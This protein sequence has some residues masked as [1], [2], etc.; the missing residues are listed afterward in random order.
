MT[1]PLLMSNPMRR[2]RASFLSPRRPLNRTILLLGVMIT[3]VVEPFAAESHA[4]SPD[5]PSGLRLERLADPLGI[6]RGRPSLGW[7]IRHPEPNQVQTAYQIQV[8][9]GRG[10]FFEGDPD[11]WDSGKVV[12]A[13]SSD[14]RYEGPE[15]APHAVYAWRVRVWDRQDRPSGYS[16]PQRFVTGVGEHWGA[17]P[18]WAPPGENA[19]NFC[20]LRHEFELPAGAIEHAIVHVT[21]TSPEPASQYVYQLFING[22]FVGCG[23]ER[24]FLGITRYNTYDVTGRV[25]ANAVNAIGALNHAAEGRQFLLR[26]DVLYRDGTR[27][28]IG[29]DGDWRAMDGGATYVDGGNA[30]HDSYYY[31]PRE[32]IDANRYPFG[33]AEPNFDDSRWPRA[34]EREAIENLKAS[35]TPNE[36]ARAVGPERLVEYEPGNYFIDFG[37]SVTAGFSLADVDSP[38]GERVEIRLGQERFGPNG[39]RY[40]KRT[41]NT[42]QE[43]W[44]L[45]E[46]RQTLRNWGYRSFRYAEVIGA[47]TGLGPGNFGAWV[48]RQPFDENDADFESSDFVLNDVWE[49]LKYGIRATSL[50]VYVDSHSRERRCYEGDA[51]IHQLSHYAMER[52]YAFPRYSMEYL[53]H[54]PTWPTE[55]KQVAVIMAWNDYMY[56]GNADALIDHYE[57]LKRRTLEEFLNEDDLVEKPENAGGRWGRDL[58][59]W[60]PALRDGFRF[61]EINTVVNAFHVRAIEVLAMIATVIG[62]RD[63]ATRFSTLASRLRP[64]FHEHLYDRDAR[65]YRDGKAIPHHSLHASIFPVALGL[66]PESVLAEVAEHI[67]ERG[68]RCNLYGA[69]FVL[70]SLYTA[71]RGDLALR[72]MTALEGNSWGHMLYRLGA[73]IPTEAWDP[74]WKGNMAFSHGGWGSA[75]ANNIARG[76]FGIRP[77]EPGF[78][79]F[80]V[81]P[82]PGGLR[83]ARY[84]HPTIKGPVSVAFHDRDDRFEMTLEVPVNTRADV[85]VPRRG[86]DDRPVLVNGEPR[87]GAVEGPFVVLRDIGSGTHR[88]STPA[89]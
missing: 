70:E 39:V 33:W 17:F 52:Q 72:H 58:V 2:V 78:S 51:Y 76:L 29:S 45:A 35:T 74:S 1:V 25:K 22:D 24:G 15:L 12:S 3:A 31:A 80:E 60:P 59:D 55:Y 47:P 4:G 16:P 64:A 82:Q 54:R 38:G 44:T 30:G 56:T 85:Y 32:F 19:S 18:I 65:A 28:V 43:V 84:R 79:K 61:S 23:P 88:F 71:G 62:E 34:V 50:G 46:G 37:R 66:A 40:R 14:V 83:W 5:P 7:V 42:Y 20:F 10:R 41:G 8:A 48:L 27:V 69:Q 13:E 21:A 49:M 9:T 11:V 86:E 67:F 63:D 75:P 6:D 87:R 57:T 77:T 68:M 81:R 89:P 36:I 53:F 73:T 26:M